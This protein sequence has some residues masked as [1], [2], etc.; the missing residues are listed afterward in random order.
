MPPVKPISYWVNIKYF[1]DK[2]LEWNFYTSTISWKGYIYIAVCECVW[3]C[4]C[5]HFWRGNKQTNNQPTNQLSNNITTKPPTKS[6]SDQTNKQTSIEKLIS[7]QR[8]KRYLEMKCGVIVYSTLYTAMSYSE[9]VRNLELQY[10]K[11]IIIIIISYMGRIS[12]SVW[13]Y[14]DSFSIIDLR[15]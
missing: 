14:S 1:I 7:K 12:D 9:W 4:V 8:N 5:P 15:C 2:K 3:L 10:I 13:V 11:M 6:A